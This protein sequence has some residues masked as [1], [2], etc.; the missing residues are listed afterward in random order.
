[1]ELRIFAALTLAYAMLAQ[2]AFAGTG[3]PS[4]SISQPADGAA[5]SGF[6]FVYASAS[7]EAGVARAEMHI[8]GAFAG[9]MIEQKPVTILEHLETYSKSA[10]FYLGWDTEKESNGKHTIKVTG[11]SV[12]GNSSSSQISARV[13]N[14]RTPPETSSLSAGEIGESSAR[15][16]WLTDE[17]SDSQVDY[18]TT[19]NYGREAMNRDIVTSHSVVISGLAPNT[20]YYYRA[21]SRDAKGN[22]A[23]SGGHEFATL[24]RKCRG[25]TFQCPDGSYV[26][27]NPSDNCAFAACPVALPTPPTAVARPIISPSPTPPQPEHDEPR[28]P[29]PPQRGGYGGS[30]FAGAS[31]SAGAGSGP[32]EQEI[33]NESEARNQTARQNITETKTSAQTE[34]ISGQISVPNLTIS[35]T[36]N[37]TVIISNGVRAESAGDISATN[38]SV[39]L[40]DAKITV[41]P[42]A[43]QRIAE[44]YGIKNVSSIRLEGKNRTAMYKI[45]GYSEKKLFGIIPVKIGYEIS[46]SAKEGS[47]QNFSRPWWAIF[48]V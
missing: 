37:T 40:D 25:D 28:I 29:T 5:V 9:N 23:T 30:G 34:S 10:T 6:V 39:M 22:L 7:D 42:D 21:K 31:A 35:K 44:G 17:P 27:R 1:M 13:S 45:R 33:K 19:D 36:E 14:D 20:T 15:I 38:G 4:V 12:S 43:A 24:A 41:M 18:G 16:S 11:Y 46:L 48:A 32:E 2:A 8:D 3:A 26:S 47:V